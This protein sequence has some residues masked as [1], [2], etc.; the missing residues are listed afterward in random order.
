MQGLERLQSCVSCLLAYRT[1]Y[2][3]LLGPP[4]AL[5]IRWSRSA[6]GKGQPCA[7]KPVS[8]MA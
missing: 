5:S 7:E 1:A 3:N 6:F 8:H 2:S 4:R